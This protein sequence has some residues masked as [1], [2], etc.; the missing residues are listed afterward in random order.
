MEVAGETVKNE[1][2]NR[3]RRKS[4]NCFPLKKGILHL[5][6]VIC[7]VLKLKR[8]QG[9]ND[10]ASRKRKINLMYTF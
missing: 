3:M 9:I 1:R 8:N 10:R 6:G 5:M 2:T 7:T 4:M